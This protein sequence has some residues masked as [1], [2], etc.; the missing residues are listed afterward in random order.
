M[1][2][3]F[4]ANGTDFRFLPIVQNERGWYYRYSNGQYWKPILEHFDGAVGRPQTALKYTNG[5]HTSYLHE[6]ALDI[7]LNAGV[8]ITASKSVKVNQLLKS[9]SGK[10]CGLELVYGNLHII[11]YHAKTS[12]KPGDR[13][14]A[15]TTICT[16]MTKDENE[17]SGVGALAPHLHIGTNNSGSFDKA[18]IRQIILT[19]I[20]SK[21]PTMEEQI[22]A[23]EASLNQYQKDLTK[24]SEEL[25]LEK[26]KNNTLVDEIALKTKELKEKDVLIT[27][28]QEKALEMTEGYEARITNL[29]FALKGEKAYGQQLETDRDKLIRDLSHTADTVSRQKVEIQKLKEFIDNVEKDTLPASYYLRKLVS[30]IIRKILVVKKKEDEVVS[31]DASKDSEGMGGS[32]F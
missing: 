13:P 3:R 29:E 20:T 6:K 22:K 18:T 24:V 8:K 27:R 17:K 2:I 10:V 14:A 5:S 31:K 26:I 9:K 12:L 32:S 25:R 30:S 15:G 21:P 28:L 4:Y 1:D 7:S 16:I 11:I 23:L 19:P